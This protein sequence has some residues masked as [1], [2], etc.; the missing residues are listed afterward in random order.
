MAK[1]R[2]VSAARCGDGRNLFFV[3]G[4][5]HPGPSD[6]RELGALPRDTNHMSL[7]RHRSTRYAGALGQAAATEFRSA[8]GRASD[9]SLTLTTSALQNL[10]RRNVSGQFP[11]V[12]RPLL[13]HA[14]IA[15]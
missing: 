6:P 2:R 8:T 9:R 3:V 11:A 12:A 7:I 15:A 13:R 10:L 4:L 14:T 5:V 1:E